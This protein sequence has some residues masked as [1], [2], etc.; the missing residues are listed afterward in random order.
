[1]RHLAFP[2]KQSL[3]KEPEGG[4]YFWNVKDTKYHWPP[5]DGD[6]K[7][8]C[9]LLDTTY[10]ATIKF[11]R[12]HETSYVD[13]VNEYFKRL[14]W[15]IRKSL[16]PGFEIVVFPDGWA[17][18][19]LPK[20]V[21]LSDDLQRALLMPTGFL[22]PGISK[23][24]YA[25]TWQWK[26]DFI[27]KPFYRDMGAIQ[28]KYATVPQL[29]YA[30]FEQLVAAIEKGL[31][32][33][34]LPNDKISLSIHSDDSEGVG[35]SYKHAKL[36]YEPSITNHTNMWWRLGMS[37]ALLNL[38]GFTR[39]QQSVTNQH[40]YFTPWPKVGDPQFAKLNDFGTY[41]KRP[42]KPWSV[43]GRQPIDLVGGMDSLWIY[44]DIVMPQMVG[45]RS[46]PLLRV[47]PARGNDYGETVVVNYEHPQFL[48]L[49]RNTIQSIDIKICNT[50]GIA[51]IPFGS[52]VFIKLH[53]RRKKSIK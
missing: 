21:T 34:V 17:A 49:S 19:K 7:G 39:A 2:L 31:K 46:V 18:M 45:N 47:I 40:F 50:Y 11:T 52:D 36:T 16:A 42:A 23:I 32:E 44:S 41:R 25:D 48:P 10:S 29:Y 35:K 9:K 5:S 24:F 33:L 3:F 28:K 30:T 14:A 26:D 43:T 6:F 4:L 37:D 27:Y 51:S 22:K 1:M 13:H 53:F 12:P 15:D 38:L 8:T 20:G